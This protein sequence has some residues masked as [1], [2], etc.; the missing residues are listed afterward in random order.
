[1]TLFFDLPILRRTDLGQ[2]V[3]KQMQLEL[4]EAR[5]ETPW[6]AKLKS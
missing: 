6:Q 2:E 3:L 1:L 5:K 4:N